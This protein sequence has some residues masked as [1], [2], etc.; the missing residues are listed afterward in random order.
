ML[1]GDNFARNNISQSLIFFLSFP[2]FSATSDTKF[3]KI[4]LILIDL[5]IFLHFFLY[6]FWT[7][8]YVRTWVICTIFC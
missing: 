2:D 7:C 6:T 8:N 5:Q 1:F 3:G 4:G